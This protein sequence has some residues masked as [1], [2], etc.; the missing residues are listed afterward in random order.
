MPSHTHTHIH[1]RSPLQVLLSVCVNN[2]DRASICERQWRVEDEYI[3]FK[4]TTP[5]KSKTK[6]SLNEAKCINISALWDVL[7]TLIY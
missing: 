4:Q 3:I 1:I 6:C 7:I 2:V 5:K